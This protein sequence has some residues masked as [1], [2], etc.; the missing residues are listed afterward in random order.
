MMLAR[1]SGLETKGGMTVFPGGGEGDCWLI[2]LVTSH[3]VLL[4]ALLVKFRFAWHRTR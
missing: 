2:R 4:Q 1:E 3:C